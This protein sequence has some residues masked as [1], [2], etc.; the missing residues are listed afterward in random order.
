MKRNY[1]FEVHTYAPELNKVFIG[2]VDVSK[3]FQ[4]VLARLVKNYASNMILLRSLNTPILKTWRL[5][6]V[7]TDG[8]KET[9][10]CAKPNIKGI[11]DNWLQAK[12]YYHHSTQLT[13]KPYF[14]H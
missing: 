9:R 5:E 14:K 8:T 6:A 10:F 11:L 1:S 13:F 3:H 12:N 7:R 4:P 2:G